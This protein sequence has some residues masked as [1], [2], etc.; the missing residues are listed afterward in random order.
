MMAATEEG[1]SNEDLAASEKHLFKHSAIPDGGYGW[2]VTFASFMCHFI[3]DGIAFSSGVIFPELLNAFGAKKATTSWIGSLFVG[4]PLIFGPVAGLFVNKYG[5]RLTTMVGGVITSV[6]MLASTFAT[7]VEMLSLTYGVVA[8]FGLAFIYVPASVMPSFWFEK[9]RALATGL[10]VSGSGLGTFAIAP[11]TDYLVEMYGWRGTMLVLSGITL[12][13]LV[14]GALFREVSVATSVTAPKPNGGSSPHQNLLSSVDNPSVVQSKATLHKNLSSSEAAINVNVEKCNNMIKKHHSTN[15]L[16]TRDEA[17]P[18]FE[19]T[20]LPSD[21]A[22]IRKQVLVKH[23][24]ASD[25]ARSHLLRSKQSLFPVSRR[26]IA[27]IMSLAAR[28]RTMSSCPQLSTTSDEDNEQDDKNSHKLTSCITKFCTKAQKIAREIFDVRLFAVPV[29]LL[30]FISN[31]ILAYAY[32]LPYLYLPDYA[33]SRQIRKSSFFIAIIGIVNT[34][35]Q[36]LFGYL[37]DRKCVDTLVLYGGSIFVCGGF[38][39]AIPLM[40]TYGELAFFSVM[41][42][43]LIGANFSLET[44]VLVKILSLEQLTRSYGLLM[45]GQGVASLIGP[46]I[47]GNVP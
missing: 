20:A 34:F 11:L 7:S 46:P 17:D 15:T 30:F 4:I 10:A 22:P 16:S 28:Q 41:F 23:F 6:G 5:C 31:F 3:A 9:K 12:N 14:F 8:G 21:T 1:N 26:D 38:V 39:A 2:V 36:I 19:C 33:S 43:L 24:S 40:A 45:F 35:G 27:S 25:V 42:G 32:D 13:F 29:Y 44:V 18:L 37:G 47:G